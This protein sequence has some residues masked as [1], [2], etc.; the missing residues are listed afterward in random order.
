MIT[1]NT[2]EKPIMGKNST[3]TPEEKLHTAN[4]RIQ[5]LEAE[6]K[7]NDPGLSN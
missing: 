7:S 5:E 1:D 4:A 6:N 2:G 3:P